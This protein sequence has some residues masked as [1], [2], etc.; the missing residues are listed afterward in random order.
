MIARKRKVIQQTWPMPKI[1]RSTARCQK[2]VT[3]ALNVV[4]ND[5]ILSIASKR[6]KRNGTERRKRREEKRREERRGG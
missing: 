6:Q 3:I 1:T 2:A 5:Q 4:A